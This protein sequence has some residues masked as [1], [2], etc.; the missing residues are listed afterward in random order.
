MT[1]KLCTTHVFRVN[2]ERAPSLIA[3]VTVWCFVELHAAESEL[4][5]THA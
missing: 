5:A 3:A 1:E 2:E 4:T